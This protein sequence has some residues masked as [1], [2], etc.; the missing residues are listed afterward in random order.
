MRGALEGQQEGAEEEEMKA[1]VM[2]KTNDQEKNTA[3]LQNWSISDLAH[4]LVDAYRLDDIDD[5]LRVEEYICKKLNDNNVEEIEKLLTSKESYCNI[6]AIR[7]LSDSGRVGIAK[8]YHYI[9]RLF[10]RDDNA[11]SGLSLRLVQQHDYHSHTVMRRMAQFIDSP[12]DTI[13]EIVRVWLLWRS[14][15][16]LS[17]FSAENPGFDN[18]V[19]EFIELLRKFKA[20]SIS[21]DA[22]FDQLSELDSI[23]FQ[24]F[25]RLKEKMPR[26]SSAVFKP[27]A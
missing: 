4:L 5:A 13:R 20:Q 9:D 17:K 25:T 14:P 3:E 23:A 6:A 26:F 11:L 8:V 16:E 22:F 10:E 2:R 7:I 27:E 19:R 24:E 18:D 15:D 21:V 1:K 12:D